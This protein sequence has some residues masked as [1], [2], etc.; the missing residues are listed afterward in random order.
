MAMT[1]TT[2]VAPKGTTG[3]LMAW[4]NY[5]KLDSE[6]VLAEAQALLYSLLRVREMKTEWAF[7]ADQGVGTIA[8]PSRFLDPIGKI[9][10]NRGLAYTQLPES[11]IRAARV[12]EAVDEQSLANNPFTTGSAG[13][14]TVAVNAAGLTDFPPLGADV[15]FAGA[16]AVDGIDM[17]NTFITTITFP[18]IIFYVEANGDALAGSVAGGGAA[19]TMT[20]NKLQEATPAAWT[21]FDEK[22]QFNAAFDEDVQCRLP[23]YRSPRL[24][25]SVNPSNFLCTRYPYLLREAC[26]AAAHR[27]MKNNEQFQIS[28]QVLTAEVQ[29]VNA[30]NDLYLRGAD[31]GTDTPTP[32][33]YY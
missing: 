14:G 18:G 26:I 6:T 27:F 9:Y 16:S 5:S 12:W 28:L 30:E 33:D 24:L 17:N 19:V 31:F 13:T 4:V 15:T 29:S 10:D 32:G 23:C 25:S 8:L 3:S 20:F 1:Y 22:L 11:D 21:I 2:L 7:S